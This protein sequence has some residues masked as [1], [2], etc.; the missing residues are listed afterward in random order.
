METEE[1]RQRAPGNVFA[2]AQEEQHGLPDDRDLRR[3]LGADLGGEI[4][5]RVPRQQISAEAE[6][7]ASG[8]S[9]RTP[10]TQVSS[11]GLRYAFRNSTLNMWAKA[12]KISRFAD[13]ECIDRMSHPN[14]TCVMMNCTLSKAS[15][16]PGR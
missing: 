1:P 11:R 3:N 10:L 12:M 15:S 16:A 2:S 6:N 5:E 14:C 8:T 4:G 7:Q 9:S 13:Q